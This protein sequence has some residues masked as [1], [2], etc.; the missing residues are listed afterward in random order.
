MSPDNFALSLYA[1]ASVGF[2]EQ[3]FFDTAIAS[4][5]STGELPSIK[6]LG[7]IIQAMALL[8]KN[9][10][11][12]KLTNWLGQIIKEKPDLFLQAGKELSEND[13]SFT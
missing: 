7:Y 9:E 13:F 10:H 8:R 2:Y 11:V 6:N 12:G 5:E 4:F 1:C 3:E